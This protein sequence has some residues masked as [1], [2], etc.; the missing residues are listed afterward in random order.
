MGVVG[1]GP[2]AVLVAVGA[3]AIVQLRRDMGA[4]ACGV[5]W[6]RR[7]PQMGRDLGAVAGGADIWRRGRQKG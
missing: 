7:V 4:V 5:L 3:S 2:G 1:I 6:I